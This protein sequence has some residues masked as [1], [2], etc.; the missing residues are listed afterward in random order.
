MKFSAKKIL[1]GNYWGEWGVQKGYEWSSFFC[2]KKI[3]G[4]LA[5]LRRSRPQLVGERDGRSFAQEKKE[6]F[7]KILII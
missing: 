6:I 3:A 2:Q 7:I 4:T 1:K 5:R